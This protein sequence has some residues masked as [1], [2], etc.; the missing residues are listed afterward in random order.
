MYPRDLLDKNILEKFSNEIEEMLNYMEKVG[1]KLVKMDHDNLIRLKDN[2]YREEEFI[3]FK[4]FY[5]TLRETQERLKKLKYFSFSH[6]EYE[7]WK[8]FD[9][10]ENIKT[11]VTSYTLVA[12]KEALYGDDYVYGASSKELRG[13]FGQDLIRQ[14]IQNYDKEE[15]RAAREEI[16]EECRES[17]YRINFQVNCYQSDI[18]E[19]NLCK[20]L[21][22]ILELHFLEIVGDVKIID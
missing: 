16:K 12:L 10:N 17:S 9:Q 6:D 21:K 18:N 5:S 13:I 15:Y 11:L 3:F 7:K 14:A 22:N 19:K 8:N 4:D 1:K 20:Y 2:H